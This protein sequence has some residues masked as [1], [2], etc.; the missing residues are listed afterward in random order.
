MQ[1]TTCITKGKDALR[2][3]LHPLLA[4]AVIGLVSVAQPSLAV[5]AKKNTV[6]TLAESATAKE[7]IAEMHEQ[8]GFDAAELGRQFAAVHSNAVVLRAI[9]PAAVPEQQRS[10][11]RYR[12]RF[13]NERRLSYGLKFWEQ[14]GATLARAQAL[15]GVPQ[16]I[17]VAIIG[18]ETE[19][20]RNT[21]NFRVLEALATLAFDYPPR[22]PFFR[23]ELEQF[24]LLA[25]ENGIEP[26]DY[27]GSYAG[28]IGIPQFMPS[29]QR[30][31]A[32]DF[33]GDGHIDLRGSATDAIG[34]VTS[35]L[36]MH[37]WQPG[38][39]IALPAGV[40]GDTRELVAAGIKPWLSLREIRDKGVQ[41]L[42]ADDAALADL[43]VALIDLVTPDQPTEYWLG[44]DN[45]Y[46]I[47][48]YNRSSFYAMSVFL[49]A[50][51]LRET[52][53]T[54]TVA[55]QHPTP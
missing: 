54:T 4:V 10:W 17:I 38:S 33:D 52:R 14:H 42:I 49:L 48:R 7:F 28:A 46:V 3:L 35:F 34:S 2:H 16:E 45:F 37:G 27:K 6:P 15:Y 32:V 44:F 40:D 53:A 11:L 43:P 41:P 25:R 24:L 18:V 21:G 8:H 20:G 39:A 12:A 26:L 55:G 5:A 22:A 1:P 30:R 51:S 31:Y 50:E 9:Q 19:Y 13:L 29:S 36:S 47:T 23:S